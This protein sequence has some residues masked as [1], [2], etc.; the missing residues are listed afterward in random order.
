MKQLLTS[1]YKNSHTHTA[2]YGDN[3]EAAVVMY[4]EMRGRRDQV[5]RVSTMQRLVSQF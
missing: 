4:V 5:C 3:N 2:V 1:H